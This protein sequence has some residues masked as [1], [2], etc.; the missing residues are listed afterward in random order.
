M[1]QSRLA[2][3][4]GC[5]ITERLPR[6]P[7]LCR[8]RLRQMLD[9][10]PVGRTASL[11]PLSLP[12]VCLCLL[13][14]RGFRCRRR[15]RRP[16]FSPPP[17]PLPERSLRGLL[18]SLPPGCSPLPPRA[19]A[20]DDRH[21]QQREDHGEGA[22]R[23][24]GTAGGALCSRRL[25]IRHSRGG[26]LLTGFAMRAIRFL[27]VHVHVHV[28]RHSWVLAIEDTE[29]TQ[30]HSGRKAASRNSRGR[31]AIPGVVLRA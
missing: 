14:R 1:R 7:A 22:A 12:P 3:S 24:A 15:R 2:S 29:L 21:E 10:D 27:H 9:G 11:L 19:P 31:V 20:R 26:G 4:I 16:R 5:R 25:P 17:S 28:F 8:R 13:R 6:L 18:P 23:G 30:M